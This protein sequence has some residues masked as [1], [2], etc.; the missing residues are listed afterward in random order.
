MTQRLLIPFWLALMFYGGI[1]LWLGP[2]DHIDSRSY[3]DVAHSLI[4]TG[5]FGYD[6]TFNI[7]RTP[8]IP[9]LIWWCM[10]WK[11]WPL[12]FLVPTVFLLA[13]CAQCVWQ[14]ASVWGRWSAWLAWAAMLALCPHI[15][16]YATRV[17]ISDA[18]HAA[19]FTAA[20]LMVWE[21]RKPITGGALLALAL[22][23]RPVAVFLMPVAFGA[24]KRYGI[25]F[26]GACIA[27]CLPW[28]LFTG[29]LELSTNSITVPLQY[30]GVTEPG[31]IWIDLRGM[32]GFNPDDWYSG[33]GDIRG[34]QLPGWNWTDEGY[35][36]YLRIHRILQNWRYVLLLAGIGVLWATDKRRLIL[37]A[38]MVATVVLPG[39]YAR[40][41]ERYRMPADPMMC[42]VIGALGRRST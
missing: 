39:A 21:Q 29:H 5:V 42:V 40:H 31:R 27:V 37:A 36:R 7:T 30:D 6:G 11:E 25:A 38:A 22:L 4:R 24:G 32:M 8:V 14:M 15:T 12:A 23:T 34:P 13:A 10:F 33:I 17:G 3:E 2:S 16:V 9:A 35:Q 19:L 1:C 26:C 28:I 41:Y 20:C 18:I